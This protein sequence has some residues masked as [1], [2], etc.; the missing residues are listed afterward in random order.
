M[1]GDAKRLGIVVC[2]LAALAVAGAAVAVAGARWRS[3][4][5]PNAATRAPGSGRP[6]RSSRPRSAEA[7]AAAGSGRRTKPASESAGL[8]PAAFSRGER[9]RNLYISTFRVRT[10]ELSL[11][12][13]HSKS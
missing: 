6:A 5:S 13:H 3:L 10:R 11:T 9:P 4:R 2:A 7:V 1:Q 12:L 8:A